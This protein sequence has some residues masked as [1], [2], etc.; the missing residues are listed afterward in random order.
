[1]KIGPID[2]TLHTFR[3]GCYA[4]P[5][6]CVSIRLTQTLVAVIM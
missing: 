6:I 2:Q 4:S 3:S 1:M 5:F